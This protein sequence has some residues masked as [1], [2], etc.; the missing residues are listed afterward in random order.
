MSG[1]LG[2]WSKED[3]VKS[4]MSAIVKQQ[5]RGKKSWGVAISDEDTIEGYTND[6]LVPSSNNRMPDHLKGSI[7]IAQ[8]SSNE[9]DNQP[10]IQYSKHGQYAVCCD[11]SNPETLRQR[12]DLMAKG[13]SFRT[14]EDVEVIANII[15]QGFDAID[16]VEDTARLIAGPHA[17]LVLAREAVYAVRDQN[18]WRPLIIGRNNN[19][20]IIAS[21]SCTFGTEFEIERDVKPG[22]IVR[23]SRDGTEQIRQFNSQK[24]FCI[25][26]WLH[27]ARVDSV[28]DRVP[29]A[30][31]RRKLGWK[32]GK[33]CTH[34]DI[35][36]IS[37]VPHSA[38]TYAEG[39][40]NI[41][42]IGIVQA[43]HRPAYESEY[44]VI[45]ENVKDKRIL[46]VDD[47]I[48]TGNTIRI[49]VEDLRRA[50]ASRVYVGVASPLLHKDCQYIVEDIKPFLAQQSSD[51]NEICRILGADGFYCLDLGSLPSAIGKRRD[52][53]CT[54][55]F[56][57]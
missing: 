17:I 25:L 21:E 45:P 11:G 53:I 9:G 26:G 16:G 8:V 6:G 41:L 40:D 28:L 3:C 47:L 29:V 19:G 14:L 31:V 35:D 48:R 32:L 15:A 2:I 23:V 13:V 33:I 4:M 52:Q 7:G 39:V 42:K 27:S 54:R 38:Y 43:F 10:I 51:A 1:V 49:L 55:C 24:L 5:H 57:K 44:S 56:E 12:I 22:E 36:V 34:L 20:F 50:G 30:R 18:G 46:L 37:P